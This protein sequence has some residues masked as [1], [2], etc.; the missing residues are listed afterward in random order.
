MLAFSLNCHSTFESLWLATAYV[1]S[2]RRGT[3]IILCSQVCWDSGGE[4]GL[5]EL[6]PGPLS[7]PL[8]AALRGEL[9][10]GLDWLGAVPA[11]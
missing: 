5:E 11:N 10:F 8:I 3:F 6:P 2:P 9:G 4:V 1:T 7:P